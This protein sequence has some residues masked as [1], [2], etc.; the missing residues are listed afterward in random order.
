MNGLAE[1]LRVNPL[2]VDRAL[3]VTPVDRSLPFRLL[4]KLLP[5]TAELEMLQSLEDI[6]PQFASVTAQARLGVVTATS[7]QAA[8][9]RAQPLGDRHVDAWVTMVGATHGEAGVTLPEDAYPSSRWSFFDGRRRV[10]RPVVVDFERALAPSWSL[11]ETRHCGFPE[12]GRCGSGAC[13]TCT[14][15]RRRGK[16]GGLIC[17]CEHDGAQG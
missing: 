13:G 17:L 6:D 9:D 7:W 12:R 10:A 15:H 1:T 3:G 8:V 16:Q 2:I 5:R 4:R 11:L 14:L